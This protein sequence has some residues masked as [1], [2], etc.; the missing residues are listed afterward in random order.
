MSERDTEP[1]HLLVL[2]TLTLL[3]SSSLLVVLV[4]QVAGRIFG[5]G[6]PRLGLL[7]A[8]DVL[9]RLPANAGEPAAAWPRED[10]L[11]LP[12]AV[13]MYASLLLVLLVAAGVIALGL[14]ARVRLDAAPA[15][16]AVAEPGRRAPRAQKRLGGESTAFAGVED[17][18]PL[19]VPAAEPGRVV[20]GW[21]YK[22]LI[23]TEREHSVLV[24]GATRSG[25]T[26]GFAI[27]TVQEWDGP[28]LVLSAKTDL[29]HATHADRSR[30]GRVLVYDPTGVSGH[31]CDGWSPLAAADTWAG[32]V[33][34]ANSMSRLS[35][36]TA[37]L[38]GAGNHW[39]RVAAQL[40]APMLLAASTGGLDMGDVVRWAM[41]KKLDEPQALIDLLGREGEVARLSLKSYLDLEP[42]AR[43][44]A[45]STV[46]TVLDVYEDPGVVAA[47]KAW[48]IRPGIFLDGSST[49]LYLVAGSVEQ[50]RLAPV[51]LALMDELLRSALT[52]SA[53]RRAST[54][55]PLLGDDGQQVPRLLVL[56]DEAANIAPLPDLATL[57]STAG[58]EGVQLVTIYQDLSQVR[59]RYGTQ[60]GSIVS[61]HVA[62]VV[63][64]GVTD[65]ETLTYF[66]QTVGEEEF[67][68]VTTSEG[69]GGKRTRSE[70]P[71]RR[72]V[73]GQRD[74]RELPSGQAMCLYG[75]YPPIRFRLRGA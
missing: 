68:A 19:A 10:A 71:A 1:A 69:G 31:P 44:S 52:R 37:G 34:A 59:H 47:T 62:K 7:D 11:L 65:P 22:R 58:G 70:A 66:S 42:R 18:A 30:R 8:S 51:F 61:N 17:I 38:G 35:G 40:L 21:S 73:V 67:L 57:A 13:G 36:T 56:L 15:D 43:D 53:S 5:Q 50:A 14:R 72:A 46:R 27:P 23:A 20:L 29:L 41:T 26:R 2:G 64:P 4:G 75:A 60:W 39:E 6:A 55:H 12:S 3:M 49:T 25:K 24:V 48:D 28:A 54:G 16:A 74:L 32:A 63:L 33:R 45:F 9:R